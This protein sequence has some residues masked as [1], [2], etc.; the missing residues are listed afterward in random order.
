MCYCTLKQ[1]ISPDL[2]S[3]PTPKRPSRSARNQKEQF[4]QQPRDARAK[5]IPTKF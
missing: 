1:H 4:H 2:S 5:T 3:G